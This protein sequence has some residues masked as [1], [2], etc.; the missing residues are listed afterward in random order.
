MSALQD[1][2]SRGPDHFLSKQKAHFPEIGGLSS[3]MEIDSPQSDAGKT[4][5]AVR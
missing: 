3:F 5:K 2:T 1:A 4:V